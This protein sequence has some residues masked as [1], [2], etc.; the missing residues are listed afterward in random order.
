MSDK[1]ALTVIAKYDFAYK[2]V[3]YIGGQTYELDETTFEAIKTDVEIKRDEKPFS[4]PR[5]Q[6]L[7]KNKIKTK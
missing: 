4:R 5:N 2:G 1:K 3:R 7:D 6:R